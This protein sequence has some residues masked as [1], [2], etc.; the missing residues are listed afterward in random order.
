MGATM[1]TKMLIIIIGAAVLIMGSIGAGFFVMWTK[2]NAINSQAMAAE[3]EEQAEA[4]AAPKIGP[5]HPLDT[6][7]VNLADEGGTRYLRT[8]MKLELADDQ[9]L[10]FVQERLPLIRDSILMILPTKNYADISTVEGKKTLRDEL[11]AKLNVIMIPGSVTNIY[12]TEF[13]VQ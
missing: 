10:T 2:V 6:F 12:F 9:S 3:G 7:I 11:I 4:P 13:V 5:I 8:T 1:S